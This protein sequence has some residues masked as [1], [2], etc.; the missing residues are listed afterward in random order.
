MQNSYLHQP[1]SHRVLFC[2]ELLRRILDHLYEVDEESSGLDWEC[3]DTLAS[4]AITCR[5]ISEPALDVLWRFI[6]DS[7]AFDTFLQATNILPDSHKLNVSVFSSD[8]KAIL[9]LYN[10][11]KPLHSGDLK[12]Y[13]HRIHGLHVSTSLWTEPL[14]QA[15][16]T[17]SQPVFPRL[18]KLVLCVESKLSGMDSILIPT[19]RSLSIKVSTTVDISPSDLVRTFVYRTPNLNSLHLEWLNDN[20]QHSAE[21]RKVLC[22]IVNLPELRH[23]SMNLDILKCPEFLPTLSCLRHL[24]ILS[25][26][27]PIV[28]RTKP[29]WVF[30]PCHAFPTLHTLHLEYPIRMVHAFLSAL[31]GAKISSLHITIQEPFLPSEQFALARSITSNFASTIESVALQVSEGSGFFSILGDFRTVLPQSITPLISAHLTELHLEYMNA[32]DVTDSL[33]KSMSEAWPRLRSL[34]IMA[35]R[36]VPQPP[37]HMVTLTGL[38][39]FALGCPEID[40]I[41][42][43]VNGLGTHWENEIDAALEIKASRLTL[44]NLQGSSVDSPLSVAKYLRWCFPLLRNVRFPKINLIETRDLKIVHAFRE[45]CSLLAD[46]K[47]I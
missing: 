43:Q 25:L 13:F 39:W 46:S 16:Q 31:R 4:L 38:K 14:S 21:T 8:F 12:K 33:C 40:E 6:S 1:A 22:M 18:T 30:V 19:L 42:M 28:D 27:A 44:L 15:L 10:K 23:L 37:A 36:D 35:D 26:T 20:T 3:K 32:D 5:S 2:D 17:Q 29:P 45:V 7:E 9:D 47:I 34:D 11:N 24:E 41:S